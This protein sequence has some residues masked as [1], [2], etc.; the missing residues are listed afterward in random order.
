MSNDPVLTIVRI[1]DEQLRQAAAD[2]L[3]YYEGFDIEDR[4]GMLAT[5][6]TDVSLWLIAEA[7]AA[8]FPQ[9]LAESSQ[10]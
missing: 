8:R 2:Q 5:V 7:I 4:A 10:L 6:D 9:I 1:L 3:G